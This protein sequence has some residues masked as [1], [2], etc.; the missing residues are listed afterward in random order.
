MANDDTTRIVGRVDA[1]GE[2]TVS[3]GQF[4]SEWSDSTQ[5]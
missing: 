2:V 3:T 5:Y 1:L 4:R